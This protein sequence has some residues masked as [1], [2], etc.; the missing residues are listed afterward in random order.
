MSRHNSSNRF[1]KMLNRQEDC[2]SH[3]RLFVRRITKLSMCLTKTTSHSICLPPFRV[4]P[5]FM[6]PYLAKYIYAI[7]SV[8]SQIRATK[9][10]DSF[11][12]LEYPGEAENVKP[13]NPT[14]PEK[15]WRH[16]RIVQMFRVYNRNIISKSF[17]PRDRS[18]RK[19]NFQL[20]Q[21]KPSDGNRGIQANSFYFRA[22]KP[23][24]EL[25]FHVVNAETV[26][27]FKRRLGEAWKDD[28]VKFNHKVT[29][30]PT[31]L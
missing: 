5:K 26:N 14:L 15:T 6:V 11:G 31:N 13:I 27:T 2:N 1:L 18:S 4:R 7:E 8:W 17:V 25:P 29:M 23:W 22:V 12:N 16:D 30:W 21:P 24:N 10:V 28:P 9:H 3:L 20:H 19:H